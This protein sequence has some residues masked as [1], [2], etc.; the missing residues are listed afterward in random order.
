[1]EVCRKIHFI[2]SYISKQKCD[3]VHGICGVGEEVVDPNGVGV[4]SC[5]SV[6]LIPNQESKYGIIEDESMSIQR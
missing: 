2:N 3:V 4:F 1:M 5:T 6:I